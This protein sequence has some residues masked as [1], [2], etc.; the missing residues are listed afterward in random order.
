[1]VDL[2]NLQGWIALG[3]T[4]VLLLVKAF[5]LLDALRR[6]P[7]VFVAADKQ[8]K[9]LWLL[10]LGLAVAAD[11]LLRGP[12]GLINLLGTVAALVYLADVR[13]A[14]RDFTPRR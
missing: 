7:E 9:N 10:L 14:V 11:V 13:P 5:A 4:L 1:M 2:N 8:T 6:P 12:F 3:L